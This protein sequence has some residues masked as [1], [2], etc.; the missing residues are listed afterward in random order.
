M[1]NIITLKIKSTH[2][3]VS[4]A[5]KAAGIDLSYNEKLARRDLRTL[6]SGRYGTI[7]DAYVLETGKVAF[8]LRTVGEGLVLLHEYSPFCSCLTGGDF[9]M[10][11]IKDGN[12]EIHTAARM[13]RTIKARKLCAEIGQILTS[14]FFA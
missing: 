12:I 10:V 6:D 9:S 1:K 14:G 8:L 3:S 7:E 13:P 5:V 4:E 11:A 2:P